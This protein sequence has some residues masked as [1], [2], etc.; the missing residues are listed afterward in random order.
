MTNDEKTLKW[1]DYGD[2]K[3]Y[4]HLP[5]GE[6]VAE[7]ITAGHDRWSI[8]VKYKARGVWITRELAKSACERI[9]EK[10]RPGRVVMVVSAEQMVEPDEKLSAWKRIKKDLRAIWNLDIS[11]RV[12]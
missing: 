10:E 6:V 8:S 9:Y 11:A 7:M 12:A 3:S 1:R 2:S 5:D 4:L